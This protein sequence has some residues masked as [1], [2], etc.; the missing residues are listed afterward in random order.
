MKK[1]KLLI[2]SVNI[3]CPYCGDTQNV[4][5]DTNLDPAFFNY[6]EPMR[7]AACGAEFELPTVIRIAMPKAIRD[8]QRTLVD[9]WAEH[10]NDYTHQ[11]SEQ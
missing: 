6:D 3:D 4:G 2:V 1:A 7:C 8:K 11:L 9:Y 5:G 10:G